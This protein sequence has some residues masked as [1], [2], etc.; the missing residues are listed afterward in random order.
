[1]SALLI[2]VTDCGMSRIGVGTPPPMVEV[3]AVVVVGRDASL[4][5]DLRQRRFTRGLGRAQ[6]GASAMPASMAAPVTR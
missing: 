2:T 1:M 5:L 6:A 4:D 3:P